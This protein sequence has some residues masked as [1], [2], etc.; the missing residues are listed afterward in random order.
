MT[1]SFK[2]SEK[3]TWTEGDKSLYQYLAAFAYA[4]A[5]QEVAD[6]RY[7]E[8]FRR[9]RKQTETEVPGCEQGRNSAKVGFSLRGNKQN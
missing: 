9:E 2:F 1:R 8:A 5:R 4:N 7:E 3:E 6:E